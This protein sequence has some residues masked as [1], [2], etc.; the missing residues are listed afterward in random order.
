MLK[1]QLR[2]PLILTPIAKEMAGYNENDPDKVKK[3]NNDAFE[4]WL[5]F[6]YLAN[7]DHAKYGSLITGLSSQYAL[8]QDQYPKTLR[9]AM[10]VLSHHRFDPAYAERKKKRKANRDSQRKSQEDA[11]TDHEDEQHEAAFVQFEARVGAAER[12]GIVLQNAPIRISLKRNGLSTRH[13][14]CNRRNKL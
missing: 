13:R 14:K 1:S 2:G 4:Q 9:D 5:S 7:T 6:V 8:G 12:K 10:N 11:T 3:C